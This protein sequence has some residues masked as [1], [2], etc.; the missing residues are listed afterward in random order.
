MAK[1]DFKQCLL[2]KGEKIVLGAGVVGLGLLGVLGV[3]N[4]VSAD[5]PS[6]TVRKLK[7]GA[8]SINTK[9][10]NTTGRSPRCRRWITE[11]EVSFTPLD[12]ER[13]RGTKPPVLRAG[14]FP[15]H[16]CGRTRRC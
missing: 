1:F 5:S 2:A 8:T 10:G 6:K 12:Y 4:A 3:M 9:I 14:R 15:E 16:S 7:T 11:H 13:V